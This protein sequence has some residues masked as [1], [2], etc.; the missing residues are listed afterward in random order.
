MLLKILGNRMQDGEAEKVEF[1]TEAIYRQEPEGYSVEYYES[2]VTGMAGTKTLIT[3][4]PDEISISRMG[5]NNAIMRFVPGEKY[6]TMYETEV[7]TLAMGVSSDKV[8]VQMDEGGGSAEFDYH[9]EINS[10]PTSDNYFS[11][12]IWEV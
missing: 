11:M 1:I 3:L 10:V 5:A 2:E 6:V 8:S 4:R 7:G 12:K 9:L